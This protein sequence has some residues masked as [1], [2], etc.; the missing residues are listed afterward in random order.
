MIYFPGGKIT[1]GGQLGSNRHQPPF[2]AEIDGFHIDKYPVSVSSFAEFIEASGHITEAEKFGDSGIFDITKGSWD[3]VKGA[4]WKYPMGPDKAEAEP[5]HPVTHVS[6][7]DAN[8]FA[9]WA[10]KRLPNEFEW[11]YAAKGGKNE[12]YTFPW[13]NTEMPGGSYMAN[14]W[15]GSSATDAVVEDGFLYT[16]PVGSYAPSE[17]GL[18]DMAGNVW[19]WCSNTFKPYPGSS[20]RINVDEQVKAIRGGSFMYDQL[21]QESYSVYGRSFNTV[22]TS[23]FN[24]GFRCVR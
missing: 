23:L 13:G 10:G 9:R 11:E 20:F 6:W 19:E 21:G 16:S 15:Q 24:T 14:T 17:S 7:N 2:E 3:L 4:Y 12:S 22:E 18:F 5:N 8:A 1:I